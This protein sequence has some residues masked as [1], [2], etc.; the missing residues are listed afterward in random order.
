MISLDII[1][2]FK[3]K[4]N[5]ANNICIIPHLNPDG[6]AIGSSLG[7]FH[8]L[9]QLGKEAHVVMPSA[10]PKFLAWMHGADTL[11]DYEENSELALQIVKQADLVIY[12]DFNCYKRSG[13]LAE[14]LEKLETDSILIDHH[15]YPDPIADLMIS[16]TDASSTCELTCNVIK[17]AAWMGYVSPEAAECFYS[18]IMTDTGSL[19]YNS[20]NPETYKI[21][22]EL[23]KIGIDKDKIHR[24]LFHSNSYNR[25][26]LLGYVLS[27]K[28]TLIPELEVAYQWLTLKELEEFGYEPGDT[29]GFVNYPLGINGINASAFFIEKEDKV[30]CSFRSRGEF[31]VNMFSEKFFNGGGHRNAAGGES[32]LSMEMTIEKFKKE[33]PTFYNEYYKN[34]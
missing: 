21:V 15:P 22:A 31:P 28:M 32:K 2:L 17:Q 18:G 25:M 27:E 24:L 14:E 30:K 7:L 10:I 5:A 6:D 26:R 13:G 29:E 23:L 8:T 1:Q 12:V 33:F 3:S 4:V 9:N 11:I 34:K 20:S 19:S 16:F